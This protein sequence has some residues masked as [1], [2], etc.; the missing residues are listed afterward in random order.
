LVDINI[1]H[2]VSAKDKTGMPLLN[3]GDVFRGA[4]VLHLNRNIKVPTP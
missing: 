2:V 4:E 1:A 3:S